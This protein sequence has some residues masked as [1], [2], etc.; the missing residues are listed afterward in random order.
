MQTI[1]TSR[2]ARLGSAAAVAVLATGTVL[3]SAT[4]AS[5]AKTPHPKLAPTMLSIKNKAVAHNH[6]HADS[7]SG[8]LTSHHKPVAGETVS[9]ESRSGKKR[10]FAVVSSSTTGSD[11]SVSFTVAPTVKTQYELV[12]AGD[13]TYRKSHSNVIT[14]KVAK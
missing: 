9:L 12:F 5:A 4:V 1:R 2:L 3:G 10:R 14:L 7:V 6:H 13:S 8:V 11:G